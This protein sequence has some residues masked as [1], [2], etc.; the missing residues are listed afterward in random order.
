[1]EE[2]AM[3]NSTLRG[4][5]PANVTSGA[6]A[7]TLS[8]NALEFIYSDTKGLTIGLEHLM[9]ISLKNYQK[10]AK[11]EQVIDIV[12]EG[13]TSIAQT[14]KAEDISSLK[15][16]KIRQ[17]NPLLNTIAGRLQLAESILPLLQQGKNDAVSRYLGIIEG[18]PVDTLFDSELSENVAV[19]Q[20]I[21]ALQRGENVIPILTDNHPMYIRAYQKLLYS[22]IVRTRGDLVQSLMQLIQER[23]TLEMQCPPELKAILRNLPMPMMQQALPPSETAPSEAAAPTPQT[24][25]SEQAMPAQAEV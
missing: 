13:N 1:M 17:G 7:A 19:T 24:Q 25:P 4:Q 21:E 2:M 14:F 10:F 16:A 11:I 12:G 3:I 5:P 8:A 20:E 9:W 22:P 15:K 6:M 18:A 23:T